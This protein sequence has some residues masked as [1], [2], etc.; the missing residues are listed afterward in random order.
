[1]AHQDRRPVN[2]D[3]GYLD[4]SKVV[5]PSMKFAGQKIHLGQE[6]YADLMSRYRNGR[7]RP[8]EWPFPGFRDGRYDA[9]LAR[10]PEL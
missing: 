3:A 1:M 9:N 6:V 2:L 5:P 8:L 4:H 7:Y 10:I